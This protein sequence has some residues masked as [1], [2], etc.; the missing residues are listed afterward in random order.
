M[1][2]FWPGMKLPLNYCRRAESNSLI[3]PHKRQCKP[4]GPDQD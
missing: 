1:K 3:R 4:I 2:L